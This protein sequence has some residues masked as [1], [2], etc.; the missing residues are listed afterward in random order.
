MDPTLP[1]LGV[2]GR[3]LRGMSPAAQVAELERVEGPKCDVPV[4][5]GFQAR[6]NRSRPIEAIPMEARGHDPVVVRALEEKG[7]LA[8]S[9]VYGTPPPWWTL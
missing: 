8:R 6:A 1:P 7:E 5:K 9:L 3:V 4:P 2:A